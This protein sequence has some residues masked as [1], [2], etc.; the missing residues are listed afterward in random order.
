MVLTDRTA[1]EDIDHA[2]KRDAAERKKLPYVNSKVNWNRSFLAIGGD[3]DWLPQYFNAPKPP[4]VR[5][6]LAFVKF[7]AVQLAAKKAVAFFQA[8]DSRVTASAKAPA[9]ASKLTVTSRTR[10]V[11]ADVDERSGV[12][13]GDGYVSLRSS[14]GSAKISAKVTG[15][16]GT[17]HY[18]APA[19]NLE[20]Y[21]ITP[22]DDSDLGG[23]V[24]SLTVDA[25]FTG[26]PRGRVLRFMHDEKLV[27]FV[28]PKD[29]DTS[30]IGKGDL[31]YVF[32]PTPPAAA[33]LDNLGADDEES[34]EGDQSGSS[35]DSN[36]DAAMS[37]VDDD[38]AILALQHRQV[39]FYKLVSD[40]AHLAALKRIA[41]GDSKIDRYMAFTKKRRKAEFQAAVLC[42]IDPKAAAP[43]MREGTSE[44]SGTGDDGNAADTEG[45]TDPEQ[46]RFEALVE[47]FSLKASSL[48]P[49]GGGAMAI[50]ADQQATA[51]G[52]TVDK[53][54]HYLE[55]KATKKTKTKQIHSGIYAHFVSKQD[56]G[57][58]DEAPEEPNF[59]DD[60]GEGEQEDEDDSASEG[61]EQ[62]PQRSAR[63]APARYRVAESSSSS[64]DAPDQD[65]A[66]LEAAE[67]QSQLEA[68]ATP[69]LEVA[70]V[71][72][73][74]RKITITAPLTTKQGKS[75][76]TSAETDHAGMPADGASI[77]FFEAVLPAGG[78]QLVANG[79]LVSSSWGDAACTTHSEA[80]GKAPAVAP[81]PLEIVG[82]TAAKVAAG[83]VDVVNTAR[84]T[85]PL[86]C[87]SPVLT[88]RLRGI[89]QYVCTELVSLL[90]HGEATHQFCC[91]QC[92]RHCYFDPDQDNRK[93]YS[94]YASAADRWEKATTYRPCEFPVGFDPENAAAMAAVFAE[95]K[96]HVCRENTAGHPG[97][98]YNRPAVHEPSG[99]A[100]AGGNAADSAM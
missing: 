6:G 72:G 93:A 64:D 8:S 14:Y 79:A 62:R 40:E 9:L 21:C 10:G 80:R 58:E 65:A 49:C 83:K 38:A 31:F 34:E 88:A 13:D 2:Y 27:S 57:P 50:K 52:V 73:S 7:K 19:G 82:E 95:P 20:G 39:V 44:A 75:R 26:I 53:P 37:D 92:G 54:A 46:E 61:R 56:P 70:G 45:E 55:A 33:D 100:G 67:A 98:W 12:I 4:R 87:G 51:L 78:E 96:L 11:D 99:Q 74:G 16:S 3:R 42:A 18:F 22:V 25:S 29:I 85:E 77:V 97:L 81:T 24:L 5:N 90:D 71:S 59:S 30:K 68:A 84:H 63:R 66:V 89:S 41:K 76:I 94:E 35:T 1:L 69:G 47:F 86:H 32:I 60:D 43:T 28:V 91:C 23:S 17:T 48:P 36:D 15:P